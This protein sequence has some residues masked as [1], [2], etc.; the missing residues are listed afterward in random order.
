[1][2]SRRYVSYG[3]VKSVR[4]QGEE[5]CSWMIRSTLVSNRK[6]SRECCWTLGS[7]TKG[8]FIE[9]NWI[10]VVVRN[11]NTESRCFWSRCEWNESQLRNSEGIR[12][13]WI[14]GIGRYGEKSG[15]TPMN[16]DW[17]SCSRV[18][19]LF[20]FANTLTMKEATNELKCDKNW[21]RNGLVMLG[22]RVRVRMNEVNES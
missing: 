11:G 16:C 14:V 2:R 4:E 19:T 20:S 15:L 8:E 3:Y 6:I 17:R 9:K 22:S 7:E 1:M 18:I 21:R 13:C 5:A 12:R 10:V